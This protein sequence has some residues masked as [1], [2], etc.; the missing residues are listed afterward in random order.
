[1]GMLKET[2]AHH[3]KTLWKLEDLSRIDLD[4]FPDDLTRNNEFEGF[5]FL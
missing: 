3:Q 1:M 2:T 4:D 5:L